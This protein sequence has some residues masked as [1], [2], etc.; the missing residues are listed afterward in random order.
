[1]RVR[2]PP[3]AL[4]VKRLEDKMKD[5]L[6]DILGRAKKVLP[7]FAKYKKYAVT[8]GLFALVVVTLYFFTGEEYIAK[9]LQIMNSRPVSGE[10][11]VPEKEFAIDA[12]EEVNELIHTYF[13]AYVNADAETLS[14][15]ATPMS[16]MELSYIDVMTQYYEE[17]RNIKCYTKHGL[18]KDSYIVAAYYEIKFI[19][20]EQTAPSLVLFYVQTNKDGDLY[21]NNL[22][23]DFNRR[24]KEN[25]VN[26]DINT[27]FIKFIAQEDYIALHHEV[28]SAFKQLIRENEE[29]YML[30]NR[31]IPLLRQEWEDTIYRVE[32][33]ESESVTEEN[34]GVT[35]GIEPGTDELPSDSEEPI[36][37]E[38][39]SQQP[40]TQ[41]P[42]TQQ[43][44][45]QQPETQQPEPQEPVVVYVK[46]VSNN[47]YVR[48]GPGTDYSK[49]G[50]VDKDEK[51]EKIGEENGWTKIKYKDKE[52]YIKSTLVKEV[53]E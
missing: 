21:I 28:D 19:D 13:E 12:Y 18:S 49:L 37:Q 42:E 53:T 16:E 25:V 41:L 48:S 51:F 3:G 26:A 38:P 33:S 24:Y 35:E 32:E 2:F 4:G 43:P 45:T 8:L 7:I 36:S 5:K 47:V 17:F 29:I 27:A 31:T 1:M 14:M 34:P 22:Y 20:I 30:T 23:S 15:L 10:A 39:A 6:M 40:E 11:Y 46:P 9:R 50:K 44:E 52:G